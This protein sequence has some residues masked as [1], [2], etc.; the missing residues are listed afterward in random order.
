[1]YRCVLGTRK[2]RAG[3][4][5]RVRQNKIRKDTDD[6]VLARVFRSFSAKVLADR[7]MVGEE[8]L[9]KGLIDNR[10]EWRRRGIVR[11]ESAAADNRHAD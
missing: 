8:L 2:Q 5:A 7:I 11:R 6:F 4:G 1:M 10:H 9:Y 3:F